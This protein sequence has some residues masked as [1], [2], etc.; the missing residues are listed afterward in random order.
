MAEQR[1]DLVE[2][3]AAVRPR[4]AN[5]LEALRKYLTAHNAGA[6]CGCRCCAAA[7]GVLRR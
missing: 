7:R 2:A 5:A 6:P 3:L 4:E 1:A